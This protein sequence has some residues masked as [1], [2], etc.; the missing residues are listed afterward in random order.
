M[1]MIIVWVE[2]KTRNPSNG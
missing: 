2:S 1:N